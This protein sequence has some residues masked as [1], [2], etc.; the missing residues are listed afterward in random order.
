MPHPHCTYPLTISSHQLFSFLSPLKGT[1]KVYF[2]ASSL[3]RKKYLAV[4]CKE[5]TT[6]RIKISTLHNDTE[7][8][9][10]EMHFLCT[11]SVWY[12]LC[13]HFG[14]NS[15]QTNSHG[16]GWVGVPNS[17]A[18]PKEKCYDVPI[19]PHLP[20]FSW[21]ALLTQTQCYIETAYEICIVSPKHSNIMSQAP[22]HHRT[23]IN[24]RRV[25]IIHLQ[26]FVF[27]FSFPSLQGSHFQD[28]LSNHET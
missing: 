25:E 20:H 27:P 22:K 24:I 4:K 28:L 1:D 8:S 9:E 18:V 10:T 3:K 6:F 16:Y 13:L 19:L 17:P 14:K 15:R 21:W 11:W 5:E 26:F 12:V 2:S 23:G 7:Q